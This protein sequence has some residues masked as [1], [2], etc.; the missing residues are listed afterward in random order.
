M[1]HKKVSGLYHSFDLITF[2]VTYKCPISCPMCLFASGPDRDEVLSKDL[3]LDILEQSSDLRIPAV[4]ITG[5]EPFFEMDVTCDIIK[6]ASSREMTS[7]VVTN[8]HWA[9]SEEEALS[10]LKVLKKAGLNRIQFSLDDQ[11]QLYI[12]IERIAN[13]LKACR[14]LE[15]ENIT[16]LGTS[17]GNS[18]K[19]KFQLFYLQELLGIS[20]AN[21][22]LIDR[23]RTSH[24]GYEDKEQ[25][26]YTFKE[27]KHSEKLALPVKKPADCLSEVMI[28]VNGDVYPCCNNFVGR[29]GNADT[30]GLQ[31]I[32]EKLRDNEF[33]RIMKEQGPFELA[34][35]LDKTQ[36]TDFKTRRYGNWCELC[37]RIFQ[38]GS[39]RNLLRPENPPAGN[40]N[41]EYHSFI[42]K[43][44]KDIRKCG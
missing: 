30:D 21:M 23:E 38:D 44:R 41:P 12:P 42:N 19:F 31:T 3:A 33:F 9:T 5:G 15:F 37:A 16:L 18:E 25:I 7:T 27:L 20:T 17:K 22:D 43:N 40:G 6:K 8:A 14:K 32:L 13:A 4:G 1:Q 24:R 26:R 36:N 39:F 35:H 2:V 11:H 29:I 10:K 34:E 28:D